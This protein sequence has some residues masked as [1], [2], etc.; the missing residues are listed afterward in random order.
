MRCLDNMT[1]AMAFNL[2]SRSM[3]QALAMV[4]IEFDTTPWFG[5]LAMMWLSSVNMIGD[6]Y[7]GGA[8]TADSLFCICFSPTFPAV[9]TSLIALHL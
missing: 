5:S 4:G 2:R 8:G 3:L 7:V 9:D 6:C 1:R